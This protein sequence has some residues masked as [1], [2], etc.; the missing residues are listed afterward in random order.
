MVLP[1]KLKQKIQG[2]MLVGDI[3]IYYGIEAGK[4]GKI[5]LEGGW[6]REKVLGSM[7]QGSRWGEKKVEAGALEE[8]N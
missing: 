7:G 6:D 5:G 3:M 8:V 1:D 2:C 4:G